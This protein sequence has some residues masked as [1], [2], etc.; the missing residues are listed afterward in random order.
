MFFTTILTTFH[1]IVPLLIVAAIAAYSV[2]KNIVS[3]EHIQGLSSATVYIFLPCLIVAKTIQKFDP[4]M[5]SFWW[6]LPLIGVA[7]ILLGLL[8]CMPLFKMNKKTFSL[9]PVAS[10][11]NGIYIPLPLGLILYK[12]QFDIFALYC[13]LIIIGTTPGMWILGKLFMSGPQNTAIR[14][15]DF[16]TPPFVALVVSIFFVLTGLSD[17]IPHSVIAAMDLLGQP[18]LPLAIFVLG[19]SLATIQL[20]DLPSAKETLLVAA[21]KFV[22]IPAAV[23]GVLLLFNLNQTLPLFCGFMMIQ[24]ASP[25]ATN[26]ILIV[27]H[28]GGNDKS[29]SSMM[30]FQH[31]ICIFALPFWLALWQWTVN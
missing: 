13:F 31:L 16:F 7:I 18:T 20:T 10:I 23:C 4:T 19:G 28:Y 25:P 21:I 24:A 30:L 8:F 12:D 2:K 22:L 6:V 26:L 9:W 11:Q 27:K 3:R 14:I 1:A 15:K 5:I 29:T 17:L